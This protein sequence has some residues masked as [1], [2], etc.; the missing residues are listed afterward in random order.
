VSVEGRGVRMETE[1]GRG[2]VLYPRRPFSAW[3]GPPAHARPRKPRA[4]A[5][6]PWRASSVFTAVPVG[7]PL[8]GWDLPDYFEET[9]GSPVKTDTRTTATVTVTGMIPGDM[10]DDFYSYVYPPDWPGAVWWYPDRPELT[11]SSLRF[12]PFHDDQEPDTFPSKYGKLKVTMELSTDQDIF[13]AF[14]LTD[15]SFFA[16]GPGVVFDS[17]IWTSWKRTTGGE[18]NTLPQSGLIWESDGKVPGN[19]VRAGVLVATV[20]HHL[21]WKFCPAPPQENIR[22][23][24]GTVNKYTFLGCPE[25]TLIY[26]GAETKYDIVNR[27]GRFWS[28]DH[29]FSEK[30]QS[31][32]PAD[33]MGWNFFL[34]PDVTTASFQKLLMKSPYPLPPG[35]DTGNVIFDATDFANLL[36]PA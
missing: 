31:T 22:I 33:P 10:E 23:A 35:P 8:V 27:H 32:D 16:Y 19:N 13:N 14:W 34:R 25:G 18:F 28:L 26:L 4:G 6:T 1:D 3:P 36:I 11:V 30:D 21:T 15:E 17:R 5:A 7:A 20:D 24:L 12:E 2:L 29:K 9:A